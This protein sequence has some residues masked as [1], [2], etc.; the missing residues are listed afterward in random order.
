M[1]ETKERILQMSLSSQGQI[2]SRVYIEDLTLPRITN[3][4][5]IVTKEKVEYFHTE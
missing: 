5:P 3:H 1:L 4:S 2:G